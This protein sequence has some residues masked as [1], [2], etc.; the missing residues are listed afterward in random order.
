MGTGTAAGVGVVLAA[1]AT[2]I[3]KTILARADRQKRERGIETPPAS[4]SGGKRDRLLL[5]LHILQATGKH[6]Q[7]AGRL[8]RAAKRNV[9][10]GTH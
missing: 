8:P 1:I 6:I 2:A 5:R 9:D 4:D 3:L 10:K 7:P